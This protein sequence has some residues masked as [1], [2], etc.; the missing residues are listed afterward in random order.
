MVVSLDVVLP[1][2]N[3]EKALPATVQTLCDFLSRC[4]S[5]YHWQVV[6]ADNGSTDGTQAIGTQLAK[7]LPGV[8]YTRLE[9][10]GRGVALRTAWLASS[11]DIVAYM[12]VDLSADLGAFP[13]LVTAIDGEGYEIA[14]GSRFEKGSKVSGR[15]ATRELLARSY[16]LLFTKAVFFAGFHDAQC[17]F[18]ALSRRAAND[19]LPLVR[20]RGWFFDTEL[21]LAE[22]NGYR[23]K[24]L[25]VVWTDD[26]D[27]RVGLLSTGGELMKGL[28]RLRFG[29]LSKASRTLRARRPDAQ[30]HTPPASTL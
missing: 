2:L 23:I 17:G 6:I 26:P 12:D 3:E 14:I 9:E 27:S 19:L 24:E 22:R 15:S 5:E 1:V 18:K 25:P 30:G 7:E 13:Q 16:S 21:L 11:A 4:L 8:G 28:L 29:G 20:S 10:R